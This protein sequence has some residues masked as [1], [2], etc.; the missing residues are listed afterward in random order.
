[1][2]KYGTSKGRFLLEGFV[3]ADV[4]NMVHTIRIG[5]LFGYGNGSNGRGNESLTTQEFRA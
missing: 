4:E 2:C 1:M 5:D 3:P